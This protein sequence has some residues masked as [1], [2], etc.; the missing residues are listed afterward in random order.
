VTLLQWVGIAASLLV[1]TGILGLLIFVA[2]KRADDQA[3]RR[4]NM[5]DHPTAEQRR[6][7]EQN[8]LWDDQDNL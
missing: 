1:I 6:Q 5:K 4:R 8:R 7:R 3:E 2:F